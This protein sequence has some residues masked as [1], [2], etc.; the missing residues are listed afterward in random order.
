MKRRT[1]KRRTIVLA[2]L[3]LGYPPLEWL[4]AEHAIVDRLLSAGTHT[5]LWIALLAVV[6]LA[7]RLA[8]VLLGPSAIVWWAW[9]ALLRRQPRP[10]QPPQSPCSG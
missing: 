8:L 10:Q 6:F 9:T 5:P 1:M 2:A 7:W 4:M 3:L